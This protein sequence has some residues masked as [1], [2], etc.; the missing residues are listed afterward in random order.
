MRF[1]VGPW[2]YAVRISE[3]PVIHEGD[4]CMGLCIADS[5]EILI[6]PDCNPKDRLPVLIHELTH[7]WLFSAGTPQTP[8]DWCDMNAM[9]F[10]TALQ[11][12][13]IQ[14]GIESLLRMGPGETESGKALT[15]ALASARYCAK[16]RTTVAGASV[17]CVQSE[18]PG[19]LDLSIYCE[20][21][22]H[23][24]RWQEAATASGFP[25]ATVIGRPTFHT[26]K[27]MAEFLREFPE[28]APDIVMA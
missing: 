1:R 10:T 2:R 13:M 28:A 9:I 17:V 25:S 14:G 27:A 6:S 23:I 20:H 8:E 22:N 26:G 21:C 7:A 15:V 5:R 24:Q 12:L 4:A 11:D 19:A 16:C 3:T 18:L